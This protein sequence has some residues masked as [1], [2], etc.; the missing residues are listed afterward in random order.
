MTY[1]AAACSMAIPW[2]QEA[3]Q[4]A[5]CLKGRMALDISLRMD[6]Q[7]EPM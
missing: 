6:F 7:N 2:T 4:S 3:S 5:T 1:L